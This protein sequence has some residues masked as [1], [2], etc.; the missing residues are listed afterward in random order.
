MILWARNFGSTGRGDSSAPVAWLGV[1]LFLPP[2]PCSI[3][4]D[5]IPVGSLFESCTFIPPPVLEHLHSLCLD[6]P[7]LS[8]D[9]EELALS[10]SWLS[11]PPAP[12]SCPE[13]T[14][15]FLLPWKFPQ[16]NHFPLAHESAGSRPSL[17]LDS[18]GCSQTPTARN[19]V[20]C[21]SDWGRGNLRLELNSSFSLHP[22]PFQPL[23][24]LS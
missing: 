9:S 14:F 15:M 8:A 16:C 20:L 24:L 23:Q 2:H 17:T 6:L 1:S 7:S 13:Q 11:L 5:L 12:K 10:P 18:L 19:P 3:S 21:V 22:P 4:G